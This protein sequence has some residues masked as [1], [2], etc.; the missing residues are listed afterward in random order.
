MLKDELQARGMSQ[1]KSTLPTTWFAQR[2]FYC[3][4]SLPALDDVAC[5]A[6]RIVGVVH[7]KLEIAE[8]MYL[9]ASFFLCRS[10]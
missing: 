7:V 4:E 8:V 6:Q 3:N 1:R 10:T 5:V 9:E 2:L